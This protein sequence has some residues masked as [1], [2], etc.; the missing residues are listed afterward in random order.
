MNELTMRLSDSDFEQLQHACE[1][2]HYDDVP[3]FVRRSVYKAVER[4]IR[5]HKAIQESERL[6][7][8][9]PNGWHFAEPTEPLRALRNGGRA[10]TGFGC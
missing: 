7:A 3:D 8:E 10:K 6:R 1:V 4:E 9:D 2:G 5:L